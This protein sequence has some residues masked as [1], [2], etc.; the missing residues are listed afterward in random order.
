[1]RIDSSGN[2]GIGTTAPTEKLDI[3]GTAIVRSTLFTVGDVH[4]FTPAYSASFFID[5]NGGT[6]Y[7]NATGGNVGIGTTSPNGKLSFENAVETRKI[8]LYEAYN[9]DYQFY[10]IGIEA[11]TLLYTTANNT[12]DHVF[13][14]GASAT[15]RNELMR[16]EGGGNVGI[17][18]TSPKSKLH[19][20]GNVQMENGGMLSFML[21]YVKTFV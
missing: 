8:V 9:N 14:S 7:F 12:D 19:V 16:I 11:N 4:G 10:G 6:S 20:D 15:T 17:G 2:V 5:N 3:S 1:M 21:K 18:T 13:F